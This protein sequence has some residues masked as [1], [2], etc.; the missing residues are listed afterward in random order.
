MSAC[1]PALKT[2][3]FIRPKES[4][5]CI[6]AGQLTTSSPALS[7]RQC[8]FSGPL[9][10]RTTVVYESVEEVL[11]RLTARTHGLRHTYPGTLYLPAFKQVIENYWCLVLLK[12]KG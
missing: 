6:Q 9:C 8:S 3:D 11:E 10:R 2:K 12:S 4:L 1:Q 7:P 5:D